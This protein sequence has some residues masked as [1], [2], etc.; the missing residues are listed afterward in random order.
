MPYLQH[1]RGSDT[2]HVGD[3]DREEGFEPLLDCVGAAEEMPGAVDAGL[4]R[5]SWIATQSY[6]MYRDLGCVQVKLKNHYV[7]VSISYW[8]VTARTWDME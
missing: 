1:E 3:W 7:K 4:A 2:I 8:S 5:Y 6:F